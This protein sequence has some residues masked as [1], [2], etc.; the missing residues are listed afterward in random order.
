MSA[1][2]F[3]GGLAKDNPQFTLKTLYLIPNFDRL[4]LFLTARY[5]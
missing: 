2:H 3:F 4:A 5:V 1:V